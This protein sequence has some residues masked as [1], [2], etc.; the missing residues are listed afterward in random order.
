[1]TFMN[2]R[3]MERC[4]QSVI[5]LDRWSYL[6]IRRTP[7]GMGLGCRRKSL[8]QSLKGRATTKPLL[9]FPMM[10]QVDGVIMSCPTT[11]HLGP[12]ENG[13]KTPTISSG[14]P[15]PVRGSA[16]HSTSSPHG[17]ETEEYSL[18]IQTITPKSC[19]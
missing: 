12:K 7:L 8:M 14:T 15:T 13:F 5:L 17:R 19:S 11:P 1:M 6:N 16:S 4:L 9:S 2:K 10:R 18:S 3:R